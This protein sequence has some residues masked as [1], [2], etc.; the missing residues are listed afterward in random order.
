[1]QAIED[2]VAR[3]IITREKA[4]EIAKKDIENSRN[5]VHHITNNGFIKE[6]PAEM[7]ESAL[8]WAIEQVS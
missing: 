1:M 3:V 5:L 7:L 8:K 6:P 4:Y 2:G